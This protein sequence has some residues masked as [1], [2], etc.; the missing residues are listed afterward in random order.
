MND[1][2]PQKID[3]CALAA[4]LKL[5]VGDHVDLAQLDPATGD[6]RVYYVGLAATS[7]SGRILTFEL[8]RQAPS[9]GRMFFEVLTLTLG[10]VGADG[11][12]E[13]ESFRS[14][15]DANAADL[16]Q[17]LP[18]LARIVAALKDK[19]QPL[20]DVLLP[21]LSRSAQLVWTQSALV[22]VAS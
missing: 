8:H 14:D 3:S 7:S 19:K 5:A 17:L 11:L 9:F 12:S 22:G 13:V 15:A 21:F 18:Q 10:C 2:K 16:P 6:Y 20:D 4:T 1:S